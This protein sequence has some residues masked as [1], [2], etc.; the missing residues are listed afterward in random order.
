[1]VAILPGSRD[2]EVE[3]NLKLML[4]AAGIVHAKHPDTRFL[5]AAFKTQHADRARE[6]LA[7][8]RLPVTVAV[9]KT[10]EILQAA[11]CC[12]A[13]SGS[14]SLEMMN[15]LKPAVIVYRAGWL[16][17]TVARRIMQVKFITLVNLLA[18]RAVYPEFLCFRDPPEAIA[19]EIDN[20]LSNLDIRDGTVE[21]LKAI[22][23]E[24][25]QPGAAAR[26]AEFILSRVGGAIASR[27]AA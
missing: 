10:P 24:V 19:A 3:R 9:R 13:V 14:V 8:S 20:W 11:D 7:D 15:A 18:G 16:G 6:M 12:I 5:V 25:A 1:M 21:A 22:K 4:A 2:R 23:A 17:V 26:A 27:R